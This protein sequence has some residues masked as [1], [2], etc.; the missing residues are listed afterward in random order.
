MNLQFIWN[1]LCFFFSKVV[2]NEID[3]WKEMAKLEN[4]MMLNNTGGR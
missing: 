4:E 3:K 1:F 2:L